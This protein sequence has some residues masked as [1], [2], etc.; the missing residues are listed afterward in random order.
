MPH[1]FSHQDNAKCV[2]LLPNA[3][4]SIAPWIA[5]QAHSIGYVWSCKRPGMRKASYCLFVWC[6]NWCIFLRCYYQMNVG[7]CRSYGRIAV[8]RTKM[9][10]N[11][12]YVSLLVDEKTAGVAT[13]L[14]IKM[15]SHILQHISELRL[16]NWATDP[17]VDENPCDY[18]DMSITMTDTWIRTTCQP[19]CIL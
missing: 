13:A 12:S 8:L 7:I 19:D 18:F 10:D 4:E 16:I 15:F 14:H 11:T 3:L 6:W 9:L 17:I 5:P 2:S 1:L